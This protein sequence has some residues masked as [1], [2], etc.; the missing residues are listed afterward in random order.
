MDMG[1]TTANPMTTV[2]DDNNG[3][4][5]NLGFIA[6]PVPWRGLQF[7]FDLYHSNRTPMGMPSF[8]ENI[9][10]GHVVYVTRRFEFLNEASLIRH[11]SMMAGTFDTTGFY[12][13]ISRE[14]HAWRPFARYNYLN[15]PDMDPIFM[16]T[17][18]QS[19]PSG[20]LRYEMNE[21]VALKL[22]FDHLDRRSMSAV[23]A[24][25]MQTSFVF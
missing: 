22:Q 7:G 1:M 21:S 2:T 23:N 5:F 9:Y 24:A 14:W 15:A 13:Q 8:A 12:S 3:R 11:S 18:R 20:G 6:K 10:T 25:T 19:G 4:A 17:G 16:T